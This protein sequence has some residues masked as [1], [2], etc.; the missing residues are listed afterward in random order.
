VLCAGEPPADGV[1]GTLPPGTART[2]FGGA[3][4][5]VG[6]Q[7][8]S[9]A[10][11]RTAAQQNRPVIEIPSNVACISNPPSTDYQIRVGPWIDGIWLGNVLR[12]G[13]R[14]FFKR[15][16]E[17][18]SINVLARDIRTDPLSA[19]GRLLAACGRAGYPQCRSCRRPPRCACTEGSRKSKPPDRLRPDVATSASRPSRP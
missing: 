5:T 13:L 10:A 9:D 6:A 15:A 16:Y 18:A 8:P 14:A 1:S 11:N 3:V 17:P 19:G 4:C 12:H 7:P 2:M